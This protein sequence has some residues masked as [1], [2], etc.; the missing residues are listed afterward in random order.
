MPSIEPIAAAIFGIAL[1]HTLS[2]KALERLAHCSRRHAG[3]FHLLGGVEVV[4]GFWAFVL[5]AAMAG[6]AGIDTINRV[7][8]IWNQDD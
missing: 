4:F 3:L 1:V 6:V 5:T 8:A 7:S 2:A